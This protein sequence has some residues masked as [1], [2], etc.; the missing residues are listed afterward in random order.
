MY[1]ASASTLHEKSRPDE[2]NDSGSQMLLV[3]K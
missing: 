1:L 2:Y 3:E